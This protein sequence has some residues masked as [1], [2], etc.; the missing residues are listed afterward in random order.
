MR[1][2]R[3]EE[4][5]KEFKC[6]ETRK[7]EIKDKNRLY[8]PTAHDKKNY[9]LLVQFLSLKIIFLFYWIGNRHFLVTQSTHSNHILMSKKNTA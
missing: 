9:L 5:D 6:D 7:E 3:I 4:T 1:K 8:Q 2:M